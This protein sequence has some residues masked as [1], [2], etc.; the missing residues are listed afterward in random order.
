MKQTLIK[1]AINF[2]MIQ[3]FLL[4]SSVTLAVNFTAS[5]GILPTF[6]FIYLVSLMFTFLPAIYISFLFAY[7]GKS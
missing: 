3:T 4:A 6:G 5:N 2:A 1:M 7:F